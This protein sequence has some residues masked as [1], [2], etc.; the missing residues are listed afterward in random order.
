MSNTVA[1][2]YTEA[3]KITSENSKECVCIEKKNQI[4][5]KWKT[6]VNKIIY[7]IYV[8]AQQSRAE[9]TVFR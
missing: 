8:H 2:F 4:I 9:L 6:C 1:L 5:N 3:H 7:D